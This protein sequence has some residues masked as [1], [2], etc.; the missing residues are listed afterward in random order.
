MHSKKIF[1]SFLAVSVLILMFAGIV[2]PQQKPA[3]SEKLIFKTL[4]LKKTGTLRGTAFHDFEFSAKANQNLTLTLTS[5]QN[6]NFDLLDAA[7]MELIEAEKSPTQVSDWAGS[8]PKTGDY[9]IRVFMLPRSGAKNRKAFYGLAIALSD[10]PKSEN[11][12]SS[13]VKITADY[14]CDPNAELHADFLENGTARIR[15]GA[16][17]LMLEQTISGSGA[18]YENK[19]EGVLFW[20]KG[21]EA[22]LESKV[23]SGVCRQR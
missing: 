4:T 18:R 20:I 23:L 12:A 16:Q 22:T 6:V 15:F 8:L 3:R 9:V 13:A 7:T 21:R 5:E 2:K 11:P 14:M 1:S 10:P 17:D 19:Q